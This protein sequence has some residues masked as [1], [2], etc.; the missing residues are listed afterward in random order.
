MHCSAYA[1]LSLLAAGLAWKQGASLSDILSSGLPGSL[2]SLSV[3]GMMQPNCD[4]EHLRNKTGSSP[5]KHIED[6]NHWPLMPNGGAAAEEE[7]RAPAQ[8]II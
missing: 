3:R 2:S 7:G 5:L 1:I 8:F 6:L 4:G